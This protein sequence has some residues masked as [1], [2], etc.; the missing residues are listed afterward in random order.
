M[1]PLALILAAVL[2]PAPSA[3][4]AAVDS[5]NIVVT[6][7][8]VP[9]VFLPGLLGAGYGFRRVIAA[10]D[11]HAYRSI[12]I[13]PLGFG[14][15]AR[16]EGADYSLTAQADR[17]AAALDT[18]ID[19]PAII[20]AHSVS[21]SIA[22]RLAYRH[23]GHVAAVVSVEGG[24]AESVTT[25]A[26]RTAMRFAPLLKLVGSGALMGIVREQMNKASADGA[27]ITDALILEYTAG[28]RRDYGAAL[29]ALKAMSRTEEPESLADNLPRIACPVV[30][31][32]GAERHR[33]GPDRHDL[34]ILSRIPRLS[35][36]TV[37]A[38]G[39]FIHEEAPDGVVRAIVGLASTTLV[40]ER[41]D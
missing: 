5:M 35:I 18:L 33:S 19:E 23:P 11:A 39:H 8:G 22:Y 7:E 29:D 9:V 1:K 40:A 6:G 28:V 31:L 34:E 24:P 26:F 36:D 30:L 10:L 25:G 37:M 21:A 16:P 12:V 38:A 41:Q 20:V 17:V 15:A 2:Q 27:W 32:I 4:P 14:A 13:E 3:P